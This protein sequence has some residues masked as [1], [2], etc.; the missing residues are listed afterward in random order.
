LDLKNQG[1]NPPKQKSLVFLER[2]VVHRVGKKAENQRKSRTVHTPSGL[3]SETLIYSF[4]H[5]RLIY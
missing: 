4:F 5:R 3:V 2:T 1:K